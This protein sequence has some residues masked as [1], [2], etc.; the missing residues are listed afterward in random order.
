MK[1]LKSKKGEGYIEVAVAVL[2]IAFLLILLVSV[3]GI[4][5]QKQD[6]KYMCSELVEIAAVNGRVGDEVQAR[7]KE[8][9]KETG[10][11][12]DVAFDAVYFEKTSGK[13]QFGDRISCTLTMNATLPGFGGKLFP[14]KL[15]I[16]LSGLS[17]IYWK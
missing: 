8:L 1:K 16:T 15:T 4:L 3:F 14:M 7:Y 11:S 2:V 17:Q 9:C 5:T 12:P 6:L 10:L 13:V